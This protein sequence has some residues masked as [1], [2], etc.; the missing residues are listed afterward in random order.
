MH[1]S[2]STSVNECRKSSIY[3]A[4]NFLN[5][6]FNFLGGHSCPWSKTITEND[7]FMVRYV[8]EINGNNVAMTLKF[9][10][11]QPPLLVLRAPQSVNRTNLLFH[12][13]VR[14]LRRHWKHCHWI[15]WIRSLNEVNPPIHISF[16]HQQEPSPT[17][18]T[19]CDANF[20]YFFI[21]E[22]IVRN[23]YLTDNA[24]VCSIGGSVS[25]VHHHLSIREERNCYRKMK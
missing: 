6:C 2:Q 4:R 12:C 1:S 11:Q 13:V 22:Q 23:Y 21:D 20:A 8:Q 17:S 5:F 16:P 24:E 15:D 10:P 18:G 25:S 3:I 14:C 7:K 19:Y 9:M